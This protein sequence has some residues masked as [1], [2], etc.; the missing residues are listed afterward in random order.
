M[1]PEPTVNLLHDRAKMLQKARQFFSERNILEVDCCALRPR[2]A[3]DANIDVICAH[4][5]NQETGYLH[6]SPEYAMKRLLSAKIGDIYF[7]GH[8]F[9]KGDI[10]PLHNPEFTMAE[11]YRVGMSFADL[12]RET[13]EF[14]FLFLPSLPIRTISYRDAFAQYVGIDYSQASLLELQEKAK[15]LS[16]H[17]SENWNRDTYIHFLLSHAIEPHLGQGELTVFTDYPPH[18]AA[19]ACVVEKQGEL[20]AERFEIYC[21]GIELANGYHELGDA[22]ELRRRFQQENTLRSSR[23][24]ETYLLDELFLTSVESYFPDCCG[25]SVGIDRALMVRHQAKTIKEVLPFAWDDGQR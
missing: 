2:A 4:V 10:G 20:V 17:D 24:K 9:R 8:V 16:A 18:E 5:S 14:L 3:I 15:N 6:T 11:W 13:C 23:G 25:V 22:K 21:Q 1:S 7:L 19:L 12:I